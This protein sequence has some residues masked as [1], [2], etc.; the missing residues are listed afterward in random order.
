MTYSIRFINRIITRKIIKARLI[1]IYEILN[2]Y[3]TL[4]TYSIRFTTRI[5]TRKIII[6][7]PILISEIL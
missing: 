5:I 2:L 6:A 4:I 3:N 1:S 7:K